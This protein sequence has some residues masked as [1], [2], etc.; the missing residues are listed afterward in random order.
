MEIQKCSSWPEE[1]V[2]TSV[3]ISKEVQNFESIPL[4][5]QLLQKDLSRLVCYVGIVFINAVSFNQDF[6][7]LKV[8]S[9][10]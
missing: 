9:G 8:I 6:V 7:K 1:R 4:D 3:C 10:F 2:K 5:F